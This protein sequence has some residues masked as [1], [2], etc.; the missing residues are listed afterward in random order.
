MSDIVVHI[1]PRSSW[2]LFD[3]SEIWRFR[4]LLYTFA[5]RNI[6]LRYKQTALGV[7]W[8]L[9]QPLISTI[10]F[11]VFFGNF[12]QI[13]SQGLP[14]PIFVLLGLVFWQFFSNS[15]SQAA[16]SFIEN[17]ALVKKVY[18]PRELLPLSTVATAAL[19]F[20][21]SFVMMLC[22]FIYYK[23]VPTPQFLLILPIATLI[24]VLASSG[25]GLLLSSINIKYRDVRYILPFFLQ[26]L[27]FVTPVIYPLTIVRPAFQYLLALNPMTGV[28]DSLR[29]TLSTGQIA[30]PE[31]LI[32]S[33]VS[34]L[35]LFMIGV[36]YFRSTERFFADVL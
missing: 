7:I 27:I 33:F 24:T 15:I 19:D 17:E 18:F 6:K 8:V 13:P 35:V 10:I 5:W 34:S 31:M 29:S 4:E 14:Y 16:N 11:T 3:L 20:V 26:L 2:Q 36:Y 30:N 1:R 9:F 12:A 23:I 28:I 22:F 25:L 21:I 32:I